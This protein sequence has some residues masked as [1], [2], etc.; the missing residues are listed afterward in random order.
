[1]AIF[2]SSLFL[3][4]ILSVTN[5]GGKLRRREHDGQIGL[6]KQKRMMPEEILQA[7]GLQDD[8]ARLP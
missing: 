4:T 1:V 5:H 8:D 6:R 7:D 2:V 3:R